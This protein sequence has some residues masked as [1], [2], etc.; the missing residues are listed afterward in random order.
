MKLRVVKR[1]WQISVEI[2]TEGEEVDYTT[3]DVIKGIVEGVLNK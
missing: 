3:K 2:D 1:F